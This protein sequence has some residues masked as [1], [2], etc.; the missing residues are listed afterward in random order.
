MNL[1]RNNKAKARSRANVTRCDETLSLAFVLRITDGSGQESSL[2]VRLCRVI[3]GI[4]WKS[5]R[6]D[7]P[8]T[9]QQGFSTG[10]EN[11][12]RDLFVF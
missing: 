4:V 10:T 3:E 9:P 1:L 2:A 5:T 11:S 7:A 8:G 6:S 12:K